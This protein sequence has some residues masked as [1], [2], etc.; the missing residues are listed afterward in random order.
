[1]KILFTLLLLTSF[2]TFAQEASADQIQQWV[3]EAISEM[4]TKGGYELTKVPPQKL[5]DAFSWQQDL[6]S[7][8]AEAA[9]PSYCTTATF[10]IFYKVLQKYWNA[11]QT[12]PMRASLEIIRPNNETDGVRIWGRWN[13]NGPATAKFFHDTQMGENFDNLKDARSGDFMKLFW[14]GEVGKKEKGHSVV[15][16]ALEKQNGVDGVRFW[17]SNAVTSGFG[18]RWVALNEFKKVMLSR[19]THPEN[20][21]QMATLPETDSYLS[22][23]LDRSS[24]WEEVR[25]VTGISN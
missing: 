20:Y 17:S 24:S 15:F 10:S 16:L 8:N 25:I 2:S 6:L 12:I 1:M 18:V 22:S 13:S 7:F 5:H 4:P 9:M 3:L 21:S 23:M 11:T 19:L 14:N